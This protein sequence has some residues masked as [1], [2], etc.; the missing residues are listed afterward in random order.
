MKNEYDKTIVCLVAYNGSLQLAHWCA[1]TKSNEHRTLG[2]LYEKMV[3][4][5]DDYA[6]VCMGK[7]GLISKDAIGTDCCL[8]VL[9]NPP[10][11]GMELVVKLR[12][13]LTAGED[14]DL[15][16]ILADMSAALNR[17][18]YLLKS[19]SAGATLMIKL[20][21]EEPYENEDDEAAETEEEQAI[22]QEEGIEQHPPVKKKKKKSFDMEGME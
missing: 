20:S 1:D 5:V 6:E 17:A 10:E 9:T 16:N 18:K 4:L 22:E 14:D 21:N 15:L 7:H 8:T 11:D 13:S 12:G 2:E 3:E 19:K